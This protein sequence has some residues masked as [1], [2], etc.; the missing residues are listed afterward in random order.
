MILES[1]FWWHFTVSHI[2]RT[3]YTDR[4]KILYTNQRSADFKI[5]INKIILYKESV[6]AC[7]IFITKSILFSTLLIFRKHHFL[8]VRIQ[9]Y[10]ES[11]NAPVQR[12]IVAK[13]SFELKVI[14]FICIINCFNHG[15]W[16]FKQSW[17]TVYLKPRNDNRWKRLPA[18]LVW[19]DL[20]AMFR[21]MQLLRELRKKD[22]FNKLKSINWIEHIYW[23]S[24]YSRFDS[25]YSRNKCLSAAFS[26]FSRNSLFMQN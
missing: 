12:K 16:L 15:Q 10:F 19:F 8:C 4:K 23:S 17:H 1:R 11:S 20:L 2:I 7:L 21:Y 26:W 25:V 5:K 18:E 6:N 13:R 24:V 9:S 3:H 22:I 14:C